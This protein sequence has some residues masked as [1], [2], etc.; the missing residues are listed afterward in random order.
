MKKKH[1]LPWLL[2]SLCAALVLVWALYPVRKPYQYPEVELAALYHMNWKERQEVC[3]IPIGQLKRMTTP[4]LIET[5]LTN[6]LMELMDMSLGISC[7][8]PPDYRSAY[9][10]VG[11]S[12]QGLAVL[13][14]R[15][16]GRA[17]LEKLY[18]E[19]PEE[20]IWRQA[21]IRYILAAWDQG[22]SGPTLAS[23]GIPDR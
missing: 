1:I 15:K 20:D 4:V 5:V 3:D 19:T 23:G 22:P 8:I 6:P 17:L 18:E 21:T 7:H 14:E 2:A 13:E 11:S 16:D 10:A 12:F 9:D